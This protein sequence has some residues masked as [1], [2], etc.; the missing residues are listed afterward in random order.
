LGKAE[1]P[2]QVRDPGGA[3]D[4][5]LVVAPSGVISTR[6]TTREAED[7]QDVRNVRRGLAD[8]LARLGTRCS[9]HRRA[10]GQV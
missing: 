2:R 10:L 6:T 8:N 1:G 7:A 5:P 3:K 4:G 9:G